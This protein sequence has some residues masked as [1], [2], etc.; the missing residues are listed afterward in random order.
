MTETPR[1]QSATHR[2]PAAG[3]G[4]RRAPLGA[5]A[6]RHGAVGAGARPLVER[7][8]QPM[9]RRPLR[10]RP[11]TAMKDGSQVAVKGQVAEVFGNKFILADDTGRA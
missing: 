3:N 10:R 5:A 9:Q 7:I 4:K 1:S 11:I 6:A 2:R 8:D